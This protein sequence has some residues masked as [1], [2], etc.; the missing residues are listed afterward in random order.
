[1]SLAKVTFHNSGKLLDNAAVTAVVHEIRSP[2][3]YPQG[4]R[5]N[6]RT[7]FFHED[8]VYSRLGREV[9]GGEYRAIYY[10]Y[11]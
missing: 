11:I 6:R 3:E 7:P 9:R 4:V 5:L 10:R 8:V 1:M 2:M